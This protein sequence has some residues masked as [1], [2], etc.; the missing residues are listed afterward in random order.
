MLVEFHGTV[1]EEVEQC[2]LNFEVHGGNPSAGWILG[3]LKKS[4]GRWRAVPYTRPAGKHSS[5]SCKAV[6]I[7]SKTIGNSSIHLGPVGRALREAFKCMCILSTRPFAWG[8]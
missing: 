2:A 1:E 6:R 5:S 7:R 8:W 3:A 4:S